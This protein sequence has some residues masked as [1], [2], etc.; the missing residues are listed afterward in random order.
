M[1]KVRARNTASLRV[2]EKCGGI[3]IGTEDTP[4]AALMQRFL[5]REKLSVELQNSGAKKIIE[6]G[7]NGV[8]IYRV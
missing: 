6:H 4:E 7:K 1:V 2:I 8:R 5:D 3:L